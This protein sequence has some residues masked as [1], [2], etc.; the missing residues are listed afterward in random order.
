[1]TYFSLI[2]Q[3]EF[4]KKNLLHGEGWYSQQ[5][6][7]AVAQAIGRCIRHAA[8]YGT[9][10]LLDSR[11]CD[12]GHYN[13]SGIP[14]VHSNLPKWMRHSVRT[15]RMD[16]RQRANNDVLGGWGGLKKEMEVFFREAPIHCNGVLKKQK[17]I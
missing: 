6:Y 16:R 14:Q 2:E 10:I 17:K 13:A 5:V 3:R 9:I 1:M 12:D 11:H 4:R 8:D 7:R 15:L